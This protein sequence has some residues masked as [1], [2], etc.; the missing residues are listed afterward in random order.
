MSA[1]RARRAVVQMRAGRLYAFSEDFEGCGKRL[2]PRCARKLKKRWFSR[3]FLREI[4]LNKKGRESVVKCACVILGKG[5]VFV[6]NTF[7]AF[8]PAGGRQYAVGSRRSGNCRAK[9]CL[10]RG[11]SCCA[12]GTS[13]DWGASVKGQKAGRRHAVSCGGQFSARA[14]VAA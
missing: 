1:T 7:P 3:S 9:C 10:R 12:I 11:A 6:P 4:L 8:E 5:V 2:T 13:V 14:I